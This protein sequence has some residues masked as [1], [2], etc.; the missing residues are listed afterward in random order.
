MFAS[1]LLQGLCQGTFF[2]S[3]H[4][5]LSNWCP[6][7]QRGVLASFAYSGSSLGTVIMLATSGIIASSIGWPSIFYFPGIAG[8]VWSVAWF[9]LGSNSPAECKLVSAEEKLYIETS[10]G[11]SQEKTKEKLSTPWSKVL[12]STPFWALVLVNSTTD[13]GY[14]TLLTQI[15]TY[16]K[17]VLRMDIAKNALLS[18]VPYCSMCIMGLVFIASAKVLRKRGHLSTEM[19]RKLFNT[20]GTCVPM[21]SLIGLGFVTSSAT[22]AVALLVIACGFN[23]AIFLGFQLN[24]MDLASNFAGTLIGVTNCFANFTGVLAPLTVGFVVTNE[25]STII[26]LIFSPEWCSYYCIITFEKHP[27]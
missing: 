15:P 23:S 16:M 14:W 5:I 26:F 8:L 6:P 21:I 9:F 10:L 12:K 13:W 4:V 20:I 27:F 17:G 25:V 11:K 7:Q 22:L 2:P 18:S 3:C 1:R 24:H 19:E